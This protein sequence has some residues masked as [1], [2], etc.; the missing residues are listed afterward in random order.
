MKV[1]RLETHDRLTKLLKDQSE[2]V[3]QGCHDCLTKN[4]LSLALQRRSPYVYI[5]GHAR[6]HENGCDK[7]IHWQPRLSKPPVQDNSF[8]FRAISNTTELEICWILPP[9]EDWDQ[10]IDGNVVQSKHIKWSINEYLY[11]KEMLSKPFH[12]DFPEQKIRRILKDYALELEQ[13]ARVNRFNFKPD[14][15]V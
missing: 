15:G 3:S 9:K 2:T 8:L 11:N 10:Y 4:S 14:Y 7:V 13:E 1:D 12:D 6:T 5:F